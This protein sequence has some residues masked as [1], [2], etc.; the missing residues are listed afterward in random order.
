MRVA[1]CTTNRNRTQHLRQTLPKNLTD[2]PRSLFIVLN[3]N[4]EDDL[5]D[6]LRADHCRDI[7]AERL[8]CYSNLA[9]PK[10]R[11]AHAKNQAH[12]LGILEGA[13]V[14]VNLDADNLTGAGFEDFIEREFNH[15]R[16][17][18]L[19]A[20]MLKGKMTRGVNGRIAIDKDAFL[21][22]GGYDES[23]FDGWG[24][25]DKDLYLRLRS[26]GYD[27][28]QIPPSYLM[29]V[30]HNDRL[31]FR[32]YPALA[33][34]SED[35]FTVDK[36][37]V[38]RSAVN[39]GFVG[40]G[41]VFRNFDFSAP[42]ILEPL[43]RTEASVPRVFGIGMHKTATTS[44]HHAF[45]ILGYDSW[46]WSSAHAAKAIWREMNQIG[47]S[48]ILE[49][50][51][52]LCDLPIPLLYQQIDRAYPGSKFILT[53]R[54]ERNWLHAVMR[55]FSTSYNKWRAGW[56][57]DPF[58]NRVHQILYGR[59]DFEPDIFLSRYRRHNAEVLEYF[60]NR[61]DDL[62][63]MNMDRGD[64]WAA[65]CGFLGCSV[66]TTPYPYLNGIGTYMM[67]EEHPA[68]TPVQPEPIPPLP[69]PQETPAEEPGEEEKQ[70]PQPATA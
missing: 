23:K 40:C 31:R 19:Y 58:T 67:S 21:A 34:Q 66:P 60:R 13:D 43:P 53:F 65:L 50:Y 1:F 17:I 39:N 64:G 8:V 61:P 57:Q 2:N 11:M 37:T 41:S 59:Q 62:L 70:D 55:H 29:A 6:W 14:L 20:L 10:F 46:H 44:L 48:L 47:R 49:R 54:D 38:A 12:R 32:E 35:F 63:I 30:A 27:G 5:L 36:S 26:L 9:E 16:G 3:Y 15:L 4:S 51:D 52:A 28:V 56:N 7:E 24:S 25:D 33:E 69:E 18:F 42:I 22:S 68:E 45:E